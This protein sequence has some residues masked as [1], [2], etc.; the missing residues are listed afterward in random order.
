MKIYWEDDWIME[1]LP[2]EL[3]LALLLAAI[4]ILSAK[5]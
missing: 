1:M 3:I 2:S 5:I 4:V